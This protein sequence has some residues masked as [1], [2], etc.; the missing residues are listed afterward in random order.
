MPRVVGKITWV[1]GIDPGASGGIAAITPD[2]IRLVTMPYGDVDKWYSIRNL[3]DFVS[4]ALIEKV[5][6]FQGEAQPGSAMFKFGANYGMMKAFLV[7]ANIPFAEV[8]PQ[9]WQKG[10]GIPQ[11][12]PGE[13]KS[14]FKSRLR[15]T[16]L[17]LYPKEKITLATCDALLIARYCQ[18]V[19]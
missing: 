17:K 12:Q 5:G 1:L 18:Q 14:Q 19:L 15:D 11:R 10:L 8:P 6:G 13:S 3:A 4:Y 7:A 16:A 2:G 9:T